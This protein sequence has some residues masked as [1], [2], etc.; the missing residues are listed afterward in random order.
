[1]NKKKGLDF[2]HKEVINIKNGTRLGYVAPKGTFKIGGGVEKSLFE[3]LSDTI[4]EARA[5]YG[6]I[7]PWYIMTSNSNDLDIPTFLRKN[8]GLGNK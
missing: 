2:K 7:I 6:A 8:K 4:K 5:Q 3:A 1:M